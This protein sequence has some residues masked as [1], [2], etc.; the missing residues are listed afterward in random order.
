V[1]FDATPS[2]MPDADCAPANALRAVM[3]A[4]G[5]TNFA[6]AL[7]Q[8]QLQ[9]LLS[10]QR[11]MEPPPQLLTSYAAAMSQAAAAM[12]SMAPSGL[13]IDVTQDAT[14]LRMT[15]AGPKLASRV[16]TTPAPALPLPHP[17]AMHPE[18]AMLSSMGASSTSQ[19]PGAPAL[20]PQMSE[21]MGSL[22]VNLLQS[23]QM[24]QLAQL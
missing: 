23:V 17:S 20:M 24:H 21:E 13:D 11:G 22:L 9:S 10:Q 3:Q 5:P 15:P 14:T 19:A 2:A 18:M 6:R 12:A 8:N 16:P 4:G 7:Q 1:L